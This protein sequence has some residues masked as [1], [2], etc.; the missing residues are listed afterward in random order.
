[1]KISVSILAIPRN[2]ISIPPDMNTKLILVIDV[3]RAT[4]SIVSALANGAKAVAPVA[5]IE[6]A[7]DLKKQL[8][9]ENDVILAG[10][11]DGLIIPGFDLGNSPQK[12][13]SNLVANKIVILKTTNGTPLIKKFTQAKILL[14]LSFLNLPAVLHYTQAVLQKSN[15]SEVLILEAGDEG[16]ISPPDH[17]CATL[18]F[19]CFKRRIENCTIDEKIIQNTLLTS[20]HGIDLISKGLSEDILFSSRIGVYQVVPVFNP[21]TGFFVSAEKLIP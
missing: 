1:M 21:R 13:T 11:K 6:E 17:L 3:L 7:Y 10:E 8:S 4:S 14:T 20:Y 2:E 18:F 16:S 5:T 12:F 9:H 19:S 15:I